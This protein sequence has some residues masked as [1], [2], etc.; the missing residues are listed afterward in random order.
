MAYDSHFQTNIFTTRL[1]FN[2]R[3]LHLNDLTH[4]F[5]LKLISFDGPE[6][7]S[8]EGIYILAIFF[9]QDNLY[10]NPSEM[11]LYVLGTNIIFL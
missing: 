7:L 2:M 10:V 1:S 5:K 6:K 4:L 11:I 8:V 9:Y 3:S